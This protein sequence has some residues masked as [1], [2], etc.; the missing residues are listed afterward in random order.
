MISVRACA[1]GSVAALLTGVAAGFA[2]GR[3]A[4]SRL[5]KSVVFQWESVPPAPTKA[6]A[7]RRFIAAPTA[8]LDELEFHVTTLDPGQSPH[9]PH[10]HPNEELILVK[11]GAVEA[12]ANG[13]WTPAS[14][15]SIIFNAS[16]Q[17][18]T[19]RNVSKSPATY[20][21]VNWKSPGTVTSPKAP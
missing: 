6:G 13:T 14:T 8:T 9:P 20:F 3:Q 19:V 21:V 15:G 12:F 17:P 10:T 18:H 2:A 5:M 11:E 16:N 1:M 4:D 7:V